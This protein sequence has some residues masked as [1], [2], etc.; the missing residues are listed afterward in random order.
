VRMEFTDHSHPVA[1]CDNDAFIMDA[2]RTRGKCTVGE[3][4]RLN[5]CRMHLRVSR[6]SEITS[7][8][9]NYLRTEVLQGLDSG[10]HP[11]EA[12]WPRQARPLRED[13]TFWSNKLRRV[14]STNGTCTA[15]RKPL[16]LWH[17]SLNP[18]EWTTLVSMH[19]GTAPHEAFRKLP[20]GSYEVFQAMPSRSTRS[21]L[22]VSSTASTTTDTL[23]FDVVPADMAFP[24]KKKGK[25][26]ATKCERV[27]I[28]QNYLS[29]P[30]VTFPCR[31]WP[32]SFS[33]HV[34]QQ[35]IHVRRILRDCDL[36]EIA[37]Q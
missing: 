17:S 15:L 12:R 10:I 33:E 37:T 30:A 3:L 20:D 29:R 6:L 2:L 7:A 9:G 24:A 5:A 32:T 35:P 8:K 13:W 22:W 31:K 16:G 14:F 18:R 25:K 1:L 34:A 4:K 27:K 21:G 36:S 28:T 11:S 19:T 23:P 26:G